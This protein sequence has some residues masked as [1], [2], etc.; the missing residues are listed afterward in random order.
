MAAADGIDGLFITLLK[1]CENILLA[2]NKRMPK[3][4]VL[5]MLLILYYFWVMRKD[6]PNLK[7]LE[8]LFFKNP[9][10]K[11]FIQCLFF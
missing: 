4:A 1:G 7:N 8:N 6:F 3:K 11:K 5:K 10:G 2:N 9:L